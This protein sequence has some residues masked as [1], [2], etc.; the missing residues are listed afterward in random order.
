MVLFEK[1]GCV[2]NL[3]KYV[4]SGLRSSSV[5]SVWTCHFCVYL[6]PR[7]FYLRTF[8]GVRQK[9]G[10]VLRLLTRYSTSS[11]TRKTRSPDMTTSFA[12]SSTQKPWT[13]SWSPTC[14]RSSRN[15]PTVSSRSSNGEKS[16]ILIHKCQATSQ[17]FEFFVP[18]ITAL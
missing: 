2:A 16:Q 8:H 10:T 14:S 1:V 17:S 6:V 18:S 15:T 9:I 13:R 11:R 12:S 3:K 4:F 7:C 5:K